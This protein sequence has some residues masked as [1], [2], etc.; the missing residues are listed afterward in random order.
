M[1]G[2]SGESDGLTRDA[3]FSFPDEE[4]QMVDDQVKNTFAILSTRFIIIII[5]LSELLILRAMVASSYVAARY[6][7]V[8]SENY[9]IPPSRRRSGKVYMKERKSADS[10]LAYERRSG[11]RWGREEANLTQ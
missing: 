3:T 6:T 9:F 1:D 11:R 5:E 2:K 8:T 4:E 7:T 10:P